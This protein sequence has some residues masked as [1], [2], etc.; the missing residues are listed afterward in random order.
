ML[1]ASTAFMAVRAAVTVK[2]TGRKHSISEATNPCKSNNFRHL[3]QQISLLH[4]HLLA[5][6]DW[7]QTWSNE[8]DVCDVMTDRSIS[9]STMREQRFIQDRNDVTIEL[10]HT[11][12]TQEAV[13]C[14][15]RNGS[16]H[17]R[18]PC[19]D[20][21]ADRVNVPFHIFSK[22]QTWQL[23]WLVSLAGCLSPLS[24][25]IYFPAMSTISSDLHVS[26]VFISL[27]VTVYM[28]VQAFA[29]SFFGALSDSRGRRPAFIITLTVYAAS[30]LA[31]AFTSS[32]MMLLV[33]RGVQAAG[34]AATISI[35]VGAIADVAVPG[36]RGKFMGVNAGT[37]YVCRMAC[38]SY[39]LYSQCNRMMAQAIGPVIGGALNSTWGFRSIFWLLFVFGTS[40][41]FALVLFLPETQHD[42]A[43]NGSIRQT[44]IRKPVLYNFWPPKQWISS[45]S[46]AVSTP[47][48]LSIGS[49]LTPLK[50]VF[51]KDICAVLI[52]GSLVYTAWSMVTSSTT[53]ALLRG[54]PYLSQWQL[55]L[56]FLPNGF[57]CVAGSLCTG[58][59]L[60]KSFR[61]VETD[62]KIQH[63]LHEIDYKTNRAFP[64]ELARLALMPHFSA[65]FIVSLALYGPSFE[66]GDLRPFYGAN[67]AAPLALQFIIA[68]T[69]TAI[70]NINSTL[71]VDCFPNGSAS[72]TAL[73]NLTRCLLGAVGVSVIQP[74]INT[75]KIMRAFIIL[76]GLVVFFSPLIWIEA[77]WGTKWRLER[78]TRHSRTS[79]GS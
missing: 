59:L 14:P 67:L 77:R 26:E 49:L 60:D 44:G 19:E 4:L 71:L 52:W 45:P 75:V 70:F 51:E 35:S 63:G 46:T 25:N 57:G 54:F 7:G 78:E 48:P 10:R 73:N 21:L 42:F 5:A 2:A 66:F 29:P 1:N 68:F 11:Q 43:G 36:E 22:S 79:G 58:R 18:S 55:G 47:M 65:A 38:K 30:N 69:S 53:T 24:S 64:Y 16:N 62:Y 3:S 9:H 33:L 32:Y 61:H 41:L 40:V 28:T 50:Y 17:D 20:D 15:G 76:T 72:A 6:T 8:H 34:S 23:V 56:C 27:T 31:L 37:R 74:L 13:I 12:G 39:T